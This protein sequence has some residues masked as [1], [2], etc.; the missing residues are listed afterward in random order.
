MEALPGARRYAALADVNSTSS[1]RL[2]ELQEAT[3]D[4]GL[5]FRSTG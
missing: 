3:Q 1:Q 2:Q 4:G 5:S